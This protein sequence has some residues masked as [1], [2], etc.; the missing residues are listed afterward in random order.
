MLKDWIA[1]RGIKQKWLANKLGVSEVS[2]S[3]WCN[4]K[5]K[6]NPEHL[7]KLS[8]ILGVD[9]EKMKNIYE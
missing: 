2:L 4:G 3:N 6:P 1:S 7:E 8:I 9:V 5:T